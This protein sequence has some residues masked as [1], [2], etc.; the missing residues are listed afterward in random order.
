M[1]SP[2]PY[3]EWWDIY[4]KEAKRR[5]PK[6]LQTNPSGIHKII[7]APLGTVQSAVFQD[8]KK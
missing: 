1:A 3:V 8:I 6:F 7:G 2:T 4:L 5:P